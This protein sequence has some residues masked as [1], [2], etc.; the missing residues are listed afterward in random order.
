V[1][2]QGLQNGSDHP[3]IGQ[4]QAKTMGGRVWRVALRGLVVAALL[5]VGA[6]RSGHA[7]GLDGERLAP[8]A[9]AAG[10]FAVE[11]PV[12]PAH[13][14]YGLGL[15]LHF[16]DDAVVV[17]DNATG[18]TVATVLDDALSLDLLASV[19]FF[20]FA[21]LA[22]HL[23]LRLV[24]QGQAAV[25]A[26]SSLDADG[27]VGDLRLVPK[28][29]FF[30]SGDDSGGFIM[31]AALPV[32][33][34]TGNENAL[35][36]AGVVTVEPRLL[37]MGYGE[38]WFLVGSAG[39]RVRSPEADFAPGHE[40]TLGVAGTYTP[41]TSGDWLDLQAELLAGW[42]PGY[43]GRALNNLPAELLVG[44]VARP[45]L[46]WS[47]YAGAGIGLTNGVATPDFR[48]LAGVRYAVGLP[49]RGGK[50]DR[51]GDGITDREDRCP[52]AAEDMDGFQDGDGCPEPDNDGDKVLDDDD[53][54]PDDAE[55]PGGD[56]DGCPDQARIVLRKGK[57]VVYGKVQFKV[58]SSDVSPKSEQ[59][60]DEMAKLLAEHKQLRRVEIQGHTD[61]TGP[62]DFN[63]KLS[64]QRAEAV[65]QGLI[66]RGVAPRRLVA[67]G[68]G[69]ESP[70]APNLTNAGRAKNRRVEFAILQ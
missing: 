40:V 4:L 55:E 8:A 44:A 50:K 67:K 14:G 30:W 23:P 51:D 11:R 13:L 35:R 34:P 38:R 16:A 69:E 66:K 7:Q 62:D 32:T 2:L 20:D 12:V 63:L 19:G 18:D 49:S 57:V 41:A 31:G 5:L 17:R 29:Q 59:L 47:I 45:A 52:E 26:G 22:V 61:A 25:V 65:R 70:V 54:C 60:L 56:K 21:E 36:G 37:A 24:Y 64:Q 3:N 58:G 43:D 33:F 68:Y 10:G 6:A 27:G 1:T 42:I 15:F 46:R 9:G 53:E 28:F 39:F 48:V